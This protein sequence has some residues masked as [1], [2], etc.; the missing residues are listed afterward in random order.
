MDTP[1]CEAHLDRY[2]RVRLSQFSY[3]AYRLFSKVPCSKKMAKQKQRGQN[4]SDTKLNFAS[5][6]PKGIPRISDCIVGKVLQ[7]IIVHRATETK[8]QN[9]L[10]L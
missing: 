3:C 10:F 2:R 6:G 8:V 5:T 7:D 9:F 1:A 4:L